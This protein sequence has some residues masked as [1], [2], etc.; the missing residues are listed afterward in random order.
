IKASVEAGEKTA[1][2]LQ[3]AIKE[4][5]DVQG[6]IN[7]A[8]EAEKLLAKLA[9]QAKTIVKIRPIKGIPKSTSSQKYFQAPK[10]LYS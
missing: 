9:P 7:A 4:V 2:E 8:N 6:K 10:G 1:D 5:E 3:T